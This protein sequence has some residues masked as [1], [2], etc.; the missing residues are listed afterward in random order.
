MNKATSSQEYQQLEAEVRHL[1][2]QIEWEHQFINDLENY[3]RQLDE[4]DKRH[5]EYLDQVE[6]DRIR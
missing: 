5:Q 6:N 2:E 4:D 1:S 3:F